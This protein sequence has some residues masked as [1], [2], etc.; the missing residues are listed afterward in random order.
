[1]DTQNQERMGDLYGKILDTLNRQQEVLSDN[2]RAVAEL[3]KR[4][5]HIDRNLDVI[6][7]AYIQNQ[8][9]IALLE[10]RCAERGEATTRFLR[11]IGC[12]GDIKDDSKGG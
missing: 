3:T 10:H 6:R 9:Q 11:T 4:L 1:M 7:L 5:G 12:V 2:V 8:K